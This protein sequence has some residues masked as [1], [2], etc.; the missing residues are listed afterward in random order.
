MLDTGPW[1]SD[2][3]TNDSVHDV[4]LNS[5]SIQ[6]RPSG[7][8][9]A[10][11]QME[12]GQYKGQWCRRYIIASTSGPVRTPATAAETS[13]IVAVIKH[14]LSIG[15]G[16]GLVRWYGSPVA[17]FRGLGASR[18][19]SNDAQRRVAGRRLRR[20]ALRRLGPTWIWTRTIPRVL[21]S[22]NA[23][24][25]SRHASADVPHLGGC[26]PRLEIPGSAS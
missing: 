22:A 10:R 21:A 17:E 3:R 16:H 8:S 15:V 2:L 26:G 24:I 11:K 18:Q 1:C 5:V 25:R 13:L 12:L 19:N 20:S 7:A 14:F 6:S 9:H 4:R 23:T